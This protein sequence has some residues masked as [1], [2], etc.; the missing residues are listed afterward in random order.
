MTLLGERTFHGIDQESHT[1]ER[2]KL[3]HFVVAIGLAMR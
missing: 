3:A 2:L 1:I